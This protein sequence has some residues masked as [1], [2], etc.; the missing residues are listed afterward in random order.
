[1]SPDHTNPVYGTA[2]VLIYLKDTTG[3]QC[4]G[5]EIRQRLEKMVRKGT[6]F[7]IS[8]QNEDGS[9]GGNKNIAG[10]MEETALAVSALVSVENRAICSSG[11]SWLD[12]FYLKNGCKASP[13]GLYFASLWYDEKLYPVTAYLETLS[14]VYEF[15]VEIASPSVVT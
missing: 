10:T 4:H 15:E 8:V 6:N 7:L 12:R 2:K 1:M 11:L 9:W 14:R 13:I 3:H 5:L